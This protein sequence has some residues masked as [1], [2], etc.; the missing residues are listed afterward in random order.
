[1]TGMVISTPIPLF[2]FVTNTRIASKNRMG[3]IIIFHFPVIL[4]PA[5]FVTIRRMN[6]HPKSAGSI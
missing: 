3:G 4:P 6:I 1:M 2:N 5:G